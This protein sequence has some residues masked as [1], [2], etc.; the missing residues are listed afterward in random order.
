MLWPMKD[1]V[2]RGRLLQLL[3]DRRGEG[4]LPF[5]ASEDAIAP[6]GGIDHRAWLQ[7][8]AELADHDLILWEPHATQTRAM[9][10]RA[11]ITERGVEVIEGRLTPEIAI[12]LLC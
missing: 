7:A 1:S 4:P 10:G 11:K 12:R 3:C 2:V 6:P 9:A 5:G 8:L